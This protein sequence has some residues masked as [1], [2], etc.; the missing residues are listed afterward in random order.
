MN[1]VSV[2]DWGPQVIGLFG[3]SFILIPGFIFQILLIG[4]SLI[5]FMNTKQDIDDSRKSNTRT[6]AV[7]LLICLL[8]VIGIASTLYLTW[9]PVGANLI[10]GVQGR[11]FLP[12]VVFVLM[13]M[14]MLTRA[15]LMV[16]QRSIMIGSTLLSSTTLLVSILWYYRIL[17]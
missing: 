1:S 5:A 4:I 17:Y 12:I 11:Y 7:Y 10:Q 6:A 14:R 8:L 2:L 15:R 16:S 13:G 9:T 3:S